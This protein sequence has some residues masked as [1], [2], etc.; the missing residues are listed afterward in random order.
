MKLKSYNP[1]T[2][3]VSSKGKP[4][5]YLNSKAGI[6]HISAAAAEKLGLKEGDFIELSQ[7]EDEPQDWYLSKTKKGFGLRNK[8]KGSAEQG[9]IFSNKALTKLIFE[10]VEY[11]QKSGRCLFG[12]EPVTL[13]NVD[14][15]PIITASL[16]TEKK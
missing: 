8:K 14:Y 2:L 4:A 12:A 3:P 15:W 13:K 7:D 6:L 9:L 16:L 1:E 11:D 5:M 10:S